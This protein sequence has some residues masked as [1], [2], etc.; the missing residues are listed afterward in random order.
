MYVSNHIGVLIHLHNI[1]V[2]QYMNI[3]ENLGTK[4]FSYK[5]LNLAWKTSYM[6]IKLKI[7]DFALSSH[8]SFTKFDIN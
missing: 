3:I 5:L 7:N 6:K 2:L 1:Q 8:D 4:I